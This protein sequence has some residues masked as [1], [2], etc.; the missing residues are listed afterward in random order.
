MRLI[1]LFGVGPKN[2]PTAIDSKEYSYTL[3]ANGTIATEK[4]GSN[5]EGM[6]RFLAAVRQS[7]RK[8]TAGIF[9][10]KPSKSHKKN[11]D[12]DGF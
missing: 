10:R 7:L 1:G 4:R 9:W 11:R 5:T 2:L 12:F 6:I 8:L 3:N